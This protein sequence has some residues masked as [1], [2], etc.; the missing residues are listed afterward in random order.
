MATEKKQLRWMTRDVAPANRKRLKILGPSAATSRDT[1]PVSDAPETHELPD[2]SG[3]PTPVEKAVRLLQTAAAVEHG[4]LV[5]YLYAGYGFAI[6]NRGI[7]DIAIEEMSHLL[8][9]Q[10]LLKLVG[11]E[12]DLSR[13]DFGP[14]ATDEERLFPFDLLLEPVTNTSLAKYVVAES[15]EDTT[16][17]VPPTLMARIGALATSGTGTAVNRVGTLYALLGAVFGSEQLLLERAATGDPWAIAVNALAAE[18]AVAYGGRDKLHLPDATFLT[19]SLP[20]QGT[21]RE[22][23]RSKEKSTDEFRVHTAVSREEALDA[24]RDIGL[25]GEGPS[26]VATEVAHFLRFTGL[27]QTFFGADGMGTE[28]ASGVLP[29]PSAARIVVDIT[30]TDPQAISHPETVRWARL[31]DHRYAIMLG[32]LEFYLRQPANDRGFLLGWC[33]AEMFAM[34]KLASFLGLKPRSSVSATPTP[35]AAVP[36][37]LPPWSGRTVAWADLETVFQASL[38]ENSAILAGTGV[39]DVQN[40]VLLHLAVSDES[41]LKEVQARKNGS[42]TTRT[43]FDRA[44]EIL[45]W[46][47]GAGDPSHSGNSTAF[48]DQSQGRFWNQTLTAFKSTTVFGES[49][50][51]PVAGGD[52]L[53]IRELRGKSMPRSRPKLEANDPEFVFLEQWIKDGCPDDPV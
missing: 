32:A 4:L 34:K 11:A 49:I 10:N 48:P 17:T 14:P 39:S 13:Q 47:T 8:T 31:A 23:D 41:K 25:Q 36:F 38:A 51:D 12:P 52:P 26:P 21:D 1:M 37:N 7:L 5:Q 16:A 45:D 35:L 24:L 6:P 43:R 22:W 2:L 29:V 19:A 33:F 18:A 46:L 28:P 42:A 44:R 15:P 40:R 50:I 20:L 53:I 30:S 27:F 9:V 3:F